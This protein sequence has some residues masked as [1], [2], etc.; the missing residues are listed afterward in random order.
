MSWPLDS[1][2]CR[3]TP[4]RHRTVPTRRQQPHL[5]PVKSPHSPRK[6][7]T[8]CFPQSCVPENILGPSPTGLRPSKL[9]RPWWV[10]PRLAD[11][12]VSTEL[13][14]YITAGHRTAEGV[15]KSREGGG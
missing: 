6:N 12:E 9:L 3:H 14:D 1:Q 11:Q 5:T 10:I 7:S 15:G 8:A 2:S 13:R 4:H